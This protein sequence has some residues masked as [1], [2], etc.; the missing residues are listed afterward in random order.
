MQPVGNYAFQGKNKLYRA[1]FVFEWRIW[2]KQ[3][4]KY[5]DNHLNLLSATLFRV[6]FSIF[7]FCFFFFCIRVSGVKTL[8]WLPRTELLIVVCTFSQETV[9][10]LYHAYSFPQKLSAK[11]ERFFKKY[12]HLISLQTTIAGIFRF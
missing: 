12:R 7:F 4:V 5:S 1:V 3:E 10:F 2:F 6:K 9:S 11:T 8:L